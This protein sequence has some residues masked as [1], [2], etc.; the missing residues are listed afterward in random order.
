MPD[1]AQNAPQD[2][3]NA[4]LKPMIPMIL[5]LVATTHCFE[6][7]TPQIPKNRDFSMELSDNEKALINLQLDQIAERDQQFR[8]YLAHGTL[9]EQKLNQLKN[10]GAKE[11]LE[12][13]AKS[14]DELTEEAR[15]LLIELQRRNDRKNHEA[16]FRLVDQY[17]Y[18]SSERLDVKAD[19]LFAVLLHPPVDSDKIE[20]HISE[21]R[22]RLLP[23]VT[24]GR[25]PAKLFAA[26]VDNMLGKI[27]RKPQLYGTNQIYDRK[28]G[29]ILPPAIKDLATT[30]RAR[31]EIGMPELGD[32]EYRLITP[33]TKK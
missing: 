11:M 30:N 33:S 2:L 24:A 28:T 19:R 12:A 20:Q 32:G 9:D 26:F 27:L 4:N 14:K 23:E 29:K 10:L 13:M 5:A 15:K 6:E 25:M 1:E 18:P 21:V 7:K 31:R 8:S 16:L 3:L 22:S 17:G